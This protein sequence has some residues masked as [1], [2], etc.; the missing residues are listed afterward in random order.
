MSV[1]SDVVFFGCWL[2]VIV[3]AGVIGWWV[4][5]RRNERFRAW[6]RRNG[7]SYS[8]SEPGL[9]RLSDGQPFGAGGSRTAREVLRGQFE[10]LAALS[11]TYEWT[12]GAGKT[13]RTHY[14][15]VI[16]LALPTSL[17]SV[18]VTPEGLGARLGKLVGMQDIGFESDAFNRAYRV[19]APDER[20]G[21][22]IV[23]PRLMERLLQPDA[24]G[25][26]WRIDGTW[27]LTWDSGKTKV[28]RLAPRLGLL[29]AVV[30]SVPRHVWLE[31]G[32]DPQT[33]ATIA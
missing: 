22:A 18:E 19:A 9:A 29:A 14:A 23:H 27:I 8:E 4:D 2:L 11:F 15:H 13:R 7:W 25:T 28:D 5:K 20:T 3:G 26:P 32:H 6:A 24:L 33:T 21:H 10:S 12:T 31:H 30:R 1:S 17:P 16:A